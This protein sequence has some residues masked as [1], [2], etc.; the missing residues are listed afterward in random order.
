MLYI[1]EGMNTDDFRSS[2]LLE[3]RK[4]LLNVIKENYLRG[5]NVIQKFTSE[6]LPTFSYSLSTLAVALFCN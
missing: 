6:A 5:S 1:A 4:D 3:L 2:D